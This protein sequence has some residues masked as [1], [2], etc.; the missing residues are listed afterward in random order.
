MSSHSTT[1]RLCAYPECNRP[2]SARSYCALHYRR[3]HV[4]GT[5]DTPPRFSIKELFW[6]KVKK[7]GPLWQGTPCWEWTASKNA[8][9]YGRVNWHGEVRKSHRV[10]Y[11]LLVG[12]IPKGLTL[13]HLCRNRPCVSPRHLEPVTGRTN[14]LRGIGASAQNARKTHCIRQHPFDLPNTYWTPKGGDRQCR[15]CIKWRNQRRYRTLAA[16]VAALV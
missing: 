8:E 3:Q 5:P 4:H 10:A 16:P 13:D 1:T 6:K 14:I 2:F 9:G 7:D 15:T 12:P 11:E